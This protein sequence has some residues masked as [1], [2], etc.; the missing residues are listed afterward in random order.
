MTRLLLVA[1][2]VVLVVAGVGR[3]GLCRCSRKEGSNSV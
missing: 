2:V 1:A 3:V